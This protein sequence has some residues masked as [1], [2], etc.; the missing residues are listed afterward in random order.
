MKQRIRL[1]ETCSG[2]AMNQSCSRIHLP[3]DRLETK[4]AVSDTA[5]TNWFTVPSM[6]ISL[7][8]MDFLS[9]SGEALAEHCKACIFAIFWCFRKF[10]AFSEQRVDCCLSSYSRFIP[11]LSPNATTIL[12]SKIFRVNSKGKLN[13]FSISGRETL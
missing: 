9:A 2:D 1:F 6:G 4:T 11:S 7:R 13:V 8:H 12:S 5:V 10:T 3:N